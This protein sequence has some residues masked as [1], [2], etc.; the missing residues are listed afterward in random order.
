MFWLTIVR[1]THSI[2]IMAVV[3]LS[4]VLLSIRNSY[5]LCSHLNITHLAMHHNVCGVHV[6][7][8]MTM[9]ISYHKQ[10]IVLSIPSPL[11]V[12]A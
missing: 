11:I 9:E 1:K 5:T 3:L 10:A 4:V 8:V 7:A 6:K 2:I 12:T